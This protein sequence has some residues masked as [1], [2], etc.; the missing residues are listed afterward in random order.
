MEMFL[1]L[2]VMIL[3]KFRKYM[4]SE[5]D[6]GSAAGI[7]CGRVFACLPACLPPFIS[8]FFSYGLSF[9]APPPPPPPVSVNNLYQ[10]PE[11]FQSMIMLEMS[12]VSFW[13]ANSFEG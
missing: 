12:T 6:W 3:F 10:L 11:C 2:N 1:F 4:K 8:I 5:L 9:P 13:E 7:T